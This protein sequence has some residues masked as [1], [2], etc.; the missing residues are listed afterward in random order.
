MTKKEL[1]EQFKQNMPNFTGTEQE[2][3]IKTA[4]YIYIELGK[5]KCFDEKYYFGNVK[6]KNKIYQL[7]QREAKNVDEVANK[8]KIICVSLTNLYCGILKDFGI[9]A[10][11]SIPDND[12]HIDTTIITR[13]ND[14]FKADLQLD[15]ENI[16][17]KSRL[18][19]FKYDG[20]FEKGEHE[21]ITDQALT[22]MLIE[23][24][25]ISKEQDYK[26]IKIE[27][28]R[29]RVKNKDA[30]R[31]LEIIIKD[32]DIYKDNEEM[33][34]IEINKFYRGMLKR[35][36]PN[37]LDKKIF[38]FNCYKE[39]KENEKDYTCCIFSRDNHNNPEI[40]LFS[41]KKRNFMEVDINKLIQLQEEGL[42]IG[43]RPGELGTNIL[44]RYMNNK[45]KE[46]EDYTI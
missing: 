32:K 29:Q 15:L 27:M 20:S 41:K 43:A 37:Y 10:I 36:V 42:V 21:I 7:A 2:K 34:V 46:I 25:Y 4:L 5:K 24:G 8:R 35:V 11:P 18:K 45:K 44:Q 31:A 33:D 17:T 13:N 16:Q 23:V 6:T 38:L 3:Q 9:T 40:Y 26:N 12:R 30:K 22:Q 1:V 28:L 19:H 14:R 39:N